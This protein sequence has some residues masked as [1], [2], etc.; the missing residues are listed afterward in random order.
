MTE[1]LARVASRADVLG[2]TGGQSINVTIILSIIPIALRSRVVLAV[3][4]GLRAGV[5]EPLTI[6][7]WLDLR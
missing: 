3:A 6:I 4:K 7:R 5:T 2:E 1:Y